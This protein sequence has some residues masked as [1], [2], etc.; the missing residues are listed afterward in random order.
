LSSETGQRGDHDPDFT[1]RARRQ[2]PSEVTA[3]VNAGALDALAEGV[4][5]AGF[6]EAVALEPPAVGDDGAVGV[7]P[8]D[9]V[10]CETEAAGT[11][12]GTGSAD[13]EQPDTAA[14][15]SAARVASAVTPP[16]ATSGAWRRVRS[17][18]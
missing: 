9:V 1:M 17:D 18:R 2:G 15:A 11:G 10:G 8:A 7:A 14:A 4:D 12:E 3:N 6:A 13:V 16:K 5:P